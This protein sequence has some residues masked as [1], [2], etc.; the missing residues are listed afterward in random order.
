MCLS[1]YCTTLGTV[2][3][4]AS[5]NVNTNVAHLLSIAAAPRQKSWQPIVVNCHLRLCAK[6]SE[7][8]EACTY[9][10]RASY[11]LGYCVFSQ[12]SEKAQQ[13]DCNQRDSNT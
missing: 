9:L 11:Y 7:V 3:V 8:R 5:V 1:K 2:T 13:V 6:L 4:I 12:E 10:R